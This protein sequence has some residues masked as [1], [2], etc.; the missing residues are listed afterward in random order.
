[1]KRVFLARS[2]ALPLVIAPG[3]LSMVSGCETAREVGCPEFT[4]DEGFGA[5][6]D[7]DANVRAF[8][9][10]AGRIHVL[11]DQMV[12]DVGAACVD[13]AL[14]A[15]RDPAAWTGLHGSRFVQAACREARTKLGCR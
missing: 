1:M 3:A 5:D 9:S 11:A 7:I 12:A 13:I 2:A 4:E 6:L 10:S 8:M 14:A 15:G